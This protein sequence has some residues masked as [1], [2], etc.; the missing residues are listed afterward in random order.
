M[1]HHIYHRPHP[2]TKE[3][4][5]DFLTSIINLTL[6]TL[7]FCTKSILYSR[8]CFGFKVGH[9]QK[10]YTLIDSLFLLQCITAV[11]NGAALT[12]VQ[13]HYNILCWEHWD[14]TRLISIVNI[15]FQSFICF[16]IL[17]WNHY[18]FHND[19]PY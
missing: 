4:N 8:I 6:H 14:V 11:G 19:W 1:K 16:I 17:Y 9:R 2:D 10:L 12:A 5:C 15:Y 3:I 18:K 13:M 7:P